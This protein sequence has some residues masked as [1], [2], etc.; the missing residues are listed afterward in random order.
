V[1]FHDMSFLAG[2]PG[3]ASGKRDIQGHNRQRTDYTHIAA[4]PLLDYRRKLA[5][6]SLDGTHSGAAITISGIGSGSV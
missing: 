1:F 5:L 6:G 2:K 3:P 4:T